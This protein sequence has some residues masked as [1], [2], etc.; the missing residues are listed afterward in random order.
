MPIGH[1]Y[2]YLLIICK[3]NAHSWRGFPKEK[4]VR[5]DNK[6]IW[7]FLTKTLLQHPKTPF[8]KPVTALLVFVS[9]IGG[10]IYRTV[11]QRFILLL[12]FVSF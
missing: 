4:T 6:N 9:S 8:N 10:C 3:E 12:I 2:F 1:T 7:F 11:F 5:E